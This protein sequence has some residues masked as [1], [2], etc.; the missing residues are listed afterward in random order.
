MVADS[1]RA[2]DAKIEISVTDYFNHSYAPDMVLRWNERSGKRERYVFLRFNDDPSWITEELPNFRKLNPI[3]YGLRPAA[4]APRAENLLEASASASVAE[5][6]AVSREFDTLVTDPGG[7]NELAESATGISGFV[8]RT[9]VRGGRGLADEERVGMLRAAIVQGFQAAREAMPDETRRAVDALEEGLKDADSARMIAFMR[10][11]WISSNARAA[12]P[13]DRRGA[14]DPGADGI[15]L[16][17]ESDEIADDAF[18]RSLGSSVSLAEL[19]AVGVSGS[20]ANLQHLIR[21]NLDRYWARAGRVV[22]GQKRLDEPE[23]VLHWRLAD[24]LLAMVGDDFVAHFAP[25]AADLV[26][27]DPQGPVSGVAIA[28]LRA[29]VRAVEIDNLELSNGDRVVTYGSEDHS[30]IASDEGLSAVA[31]AL[32]TAVVKRATVSAGN[33]RLSLDFVTR[34]VSG[35]TSARPSLADLLEVGVPLLW[36]LTEAQESAITALLAEAAARAGQGDASGA[37]SLPDPLF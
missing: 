13:A 35:Q 14:A 29:R 21:T 1:L 12:F 37:G 9:I 7:A 19:T 17:L 20:P 26:R 4:A 27:V 16:L 24:G 28:E 6:A 2:I 15:A 18:W 32:G 25:A 22:P 5:L 10:A 8:S 3:V 31:E 36:P 33:R 34:T 11:M 23:G 30:N